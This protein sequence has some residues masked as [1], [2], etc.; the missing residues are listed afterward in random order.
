ME[1]RTLGRTGLRVSAISLGTE[2]L[3]N[4]PREHVARVIHAALERGINYFDLF[5]AQPAFRDNMGAA[6][7]GHRQRA[8]LTAHLGAIEE[9]GQGARSRDPDLSAR[10][11]LEYLRRYETDYV[12]ILFLH[13]SDGQ[14][15]Y[16]LVMRPDGLLGMAQAYQRAGQARSIGF[17]GHTVCTALQ[18]VRSGQID[19]LMFPI[20]LASHAVEGKRE[21]YA[22]CAAHN[23]ALVAMKPY[24][25]GRLLQ[26]GATMN[27][28][29]WQTGG[30]DMEL[31]KLPAITAVRCLAYVL[32][33]AGVSTI[34]PGC[35]NVEELDAALAYWEASAEER[36]F[37]P[38]LS[39]FDQYVSGEC[40][41]CNHCLPCPQ[42]I[43]IGHTLR[44]LDLAMQGPRPS[45]AVLDEYFA[46][47]TDATDCIACGACEVRCPFDV[48]VIA[49]MEAAAG[50]LNR[51]GSAPRVA[52]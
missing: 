36:D 12:D 29:T 11:F 41:Y 15:D 40:V 22:A 49:K 27:L 5:W 6:F 18:A 26:Q 28:E 46:M 23:V 48:G 17:S 24:G 47:E 34:V 1:Q 20:N 25:G 44:L 8:L 3:I 4:Q 13:N 45:A 42:H 30:P 31:T 2:Y 51:G 38:L 21:L 16:D 10:F 39:Q 19:L 37:G 43:D 32:A 9:D 33:Q 35:K 14:E 52:H 7:K 50:L